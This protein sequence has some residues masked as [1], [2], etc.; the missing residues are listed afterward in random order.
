[1]NLSPEES[2]LIDRA[3]L[4]ELASEEEALFAEA[5]KSPDFREAYDLRKTMVSAIDEQ[6]ESQLRAELKEFFKDLS[7][8]SSPRNWYLAAAS[9]AAILIAGL[10]LLPT[11]SSIYDEY[12]SDF[13][14][15]P[16]FRAE[17]TDDGAFFKS[18]KLGDWQQAIVELKDYEGVY[19]DVYLGCAH[20]NLDEYTEAQF[21]FEQATQ[22]DNTLVG[23]V[24]TWYLAL[25]ALEKEEMDS[26]KAQ[27]QAI[28]IG[29]GPYAKEAHSL[30]KKLF[31]ALY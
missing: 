6:E 7:A 18:Y 2:E 10:V 31:F 12:Y 29:Q 15:S 11:R 22:N 8:S 9:I 30:L 27:L 14:A 19:R 26:A 17:G 25:L 13:P 24:G 5:M 3:L 16:S 20:L 4:D 23:H 1:M 21:Y 28:A